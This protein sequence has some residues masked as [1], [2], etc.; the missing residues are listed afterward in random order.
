MTAPFK[1]HFSTGSANYAAH[2]P[3]YPAQLVDELAALCP[4]T[5][6][7]LDC[8]CGTGQLTVLLAERFER[9]VGTDASAAQI[10]K[11]QARERVE[12]RVALA[13]DSGLAA[14]SADLVTVA[15]AA[16]WL[17]LP[18]FYE[19]VRRVAR[20]DA[21]LALVTYGVL[22]VDGPMEPLVQHFYHQVVDPYWP[23][24]R[25]HV[26]EGYRSLPFPFEERR[27]PDLA[28]EVAWT[29]DELLGYVG[30][31]SAVKEAGKALGQDPGA[32]FVDELREAWGDPQ[33]RYRV[34]WP[35]TVRAGVI[36]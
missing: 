20:A 18:R 4:G 19:E 26:E 28:I 33:T 13:E 10:D 30:T 11:A 16:H 14:A 3:T 17:D 12:Y 15:Q 36:R 31:W 25:R 8:G 34:S 7:A 23:A 27:L 21:I 22:H 1:D 2:R 29:L 6:L 5:R 35:L 32:A 24:E 9:V